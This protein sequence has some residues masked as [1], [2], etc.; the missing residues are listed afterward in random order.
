MGMSNPQCDRI[1]HALADPTRRSIFEHLSHGGELT[2][3]ELIKHAR[4]T[5]Q[6]VAQHLSVL[7]LAGLV[8]V[9]RYGGTTNYYRAR[10]S[11]GDPLLS[12]LVEQGI[13]PTN[14]QT[15]QPSASNTDEEVLTV[16]TRERAEYVASISQAIAVLKET[17]DKAN[18][19]F[20][21]ATRSAIEAPD[22]KQV[23][24]SVAHLPHSTTR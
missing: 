9:Y 20:L 4:V 24:S 22:E 12:W 3:R 10:P 7:Q 21:F 15:A 16:Y 14:K 23:Q 5:Q 17:C 13:L 18:V 11:G 6:A 1:F 8:T 19:E 2:V